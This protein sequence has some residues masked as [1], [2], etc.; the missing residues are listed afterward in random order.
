MQS[1]WRYQIA[2]KLYDSTPNLQTLAKARQQI[3]AID[4]IE[5]LR[6]AL[7]VTSETLISIDN[8]LGH[9]GTRE[10]AHDAL[11]RLR[12]LLWGLGL[13]PVDSFN[14]PAL[15][16]RGSLIEALERSGFRGS[17]DGDIRRILPDQPGWELAKGE[18]LAEALQQTVSEERLDQWFRE[19]EAAAMRDVRENSLTQCP[20]EEDLAEKWWSRG[21]SCQSR[22]IQATRAKSRL[23]AQVGNLPVKFGSP[24]IE[25][26]MMI[27]A[28]R[29]H[30]GRRTYAVSEFC[31]FLIRVWSSLDDRTQRLIRHELQ[32]AFQKEE[33]ARLLGDRYLPLGDECDRAEWEKVRRT[34]EGDKPKGVWTCDV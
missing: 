30:L 23:S 1:D 12:R 11:W 9:A 8:W 32:Q 20:Y 28:F 21:Y 6:F 17:E 33:E 4:D 31:N 5:L 14:S 3:D 15:S 22:L 10:A 18:T 13:N 29:Y 27:G 26:M 24:D 16:W 7:L 25:L 34:I 19:G 2:L